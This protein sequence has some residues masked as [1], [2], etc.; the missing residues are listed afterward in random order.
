MTKTNNYADDGKGNCLN[1]PSECWTC[2]Y[3]KLYGQYHCSKPNHKTY[4]TTSL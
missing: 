3:F 2:V 4:A 1:Y